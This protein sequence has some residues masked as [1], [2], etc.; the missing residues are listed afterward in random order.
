MTKY[1]NSNKIDLW[2]IKTN[3]EKEFY[4][5]TAEEIINFLNSQ[6]PYFSKYR[7]APS[8]KNPEKVQVSNP[9]GTVESSSYDQENIE[10]K[11]VITDE[12]GKYKFKLPI[13]TCC[14]CYQKG[15]LENILVVGLFTDPNDPT[16][17]NL[18]KLG[19]NKDRETMDSVLQANNFPNY[20]DI[21]RLYDQIKKIEKVQEKVETLKTSL[22]Q[23]RIA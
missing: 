9:S 23:A 19:S 7:Q 4:C 14:V 12:I 18:I 10:Y 11:I 2:K 20:N 5:Y 8:V 22:E 3:Q 6:M 15:S 16:K 13:D 17:A 21:L 1:I